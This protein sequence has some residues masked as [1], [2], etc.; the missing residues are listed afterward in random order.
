MIFILTFVFPQVYITLNTPFRL[1]NTI[2][3]NLLQDK[4]KTCEIS[5]AGLNLAD[6]FSLGV[7]WKI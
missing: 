1:T 6:T 2:K 7:L 4:I 3:S 5:I